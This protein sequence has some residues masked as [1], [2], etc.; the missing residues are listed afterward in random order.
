[1]LNGL[2]PYAC[3]GIWNWG[4]I[5][6]ALNKGPRSSW[7]LAGEG[8]KQRQTRAERIKVKLPEAE[9]WGLRSGEE[10]RMVRNHAASISSAGLPQ[11]YVRKAGEEC[12]FYIGTPYGYHI[13]LYL[14]GSV[15][16]LSSQAEYSP[17]WRVFDKYAL[18]LG[19]ML[20]YKA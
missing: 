18:E 17:A 1:M 4:Q 20:K 15:N 19:P 7:T 11:V 13:P 9:R 2:E 14:L 6:D 5:E 10:I 8:R 3:Y 16:P 12:A